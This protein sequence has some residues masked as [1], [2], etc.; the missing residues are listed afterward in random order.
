MAIDGLK[1]IEPVG[2]GQSHGSRTTVADST[3]KATG[4]GAASIG[5]AAA[6]ARLQQHLDSLRE[7]SQFSV[8]YLSGLD[9]VTVRDT[10]TGEVIRQIPSAEA[11]RL[12]QL[13]RKGDLSGPTAFLNITI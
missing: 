11:V 4:P 2:G 9:V 1:S 6:V 3:S 10:N 13:L 12:A 7:N 8:D 5:I